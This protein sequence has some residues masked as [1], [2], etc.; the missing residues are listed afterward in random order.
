MKAKD[1]LA[2]KGNTI[3]A[4]SPDQTVLDALKVMAAKNIGAVLVMKENELLGIF[5]ERDYAR[6]IVLKGKTSADSLVSEVMVSPLHTINPENNLNECMQLMTDKTIRHLPIIDNGKLIGL[7][8][9]GDV[10]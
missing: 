2:V 1:I 4:V 6:K 3:I 9:I 7:I 10:V 8:S 5:S